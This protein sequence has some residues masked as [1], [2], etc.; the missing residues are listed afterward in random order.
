MDNPFPFSVVLFDLDG[1]IID[2]APG[3]IL[4]LQDTILELGR[5]A[6]SPQ[7]LRSWLGPP[8]PLSFTTHLGIKSTELASALRIFAAKYSAAG[9]FQSH[10]YPGMREVLRGVWDAG[11]PSSTATS[12]IE[13]HA[14]LVLDHFSLSP[15]LNFITGASEDETRSA[16]TLVVQ[17]ALT[18]LHE[19]GADISRPVLIG[20]RHH[21]VDG[22]LDNGVPT[23]MAAWG[24]G[25]PSEHAGS[26]DVAARPEDLV[27]LLGIQAGPL[28]PAW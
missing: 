1:T 26:I 4:A 17:D 24:Y 27:G 21:D 14:K 15:Y 25:S 23:I 11:I 7:E 10:V 12:K 6:P 19:S 5:P 8:L 16:K 3:V 20:D 22:G 13:S 2:S 28:A 9:A 18:R